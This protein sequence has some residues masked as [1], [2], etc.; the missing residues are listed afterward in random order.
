MSFP[1]YYEDTDFSGFVYH[2]NYLKF[3]ERAREHVIGIDFL[4][5]MFKERLHFVVSKAEI[6]FLKPAVHGDKIWIETTAKI[7]KSPVVEFY[8]NAVHESSEM[9]VKSVITI[10]LINDQRKPQK[11]PPAFIEH[12]ERQAELINK[13][14]HL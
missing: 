3:F 9:L 4:A 13:G 14:Y 11:M 12:F 5:Q 7:A 1:I 10:V 8:Q 2:A 6:S